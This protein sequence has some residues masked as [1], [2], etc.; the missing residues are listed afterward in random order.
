MNFTLWL[1]NIETSQIKPE[2]RTLLWKRS[3]GWKKL[4][5]QPPC[6]I[7]GRHISSLETG[8][9]R[10]K[11]LS[12]Y[13]KGIL[14]LVLFEQVFPE[15]TQTFTKRCEAISGMNFKD[16]IIASLQSVHSPE[17]IREQAEELYHL[18]SKVKISYDWF[19]STDFGRS[20]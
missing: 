9:M 1:E 5:N 12:Y 15:E 17:E 11:M 4:L 6:P 7:L 19:W 18:N 20:L 16:L 8:D 14:N 10:S 2:F 13:M 3:R